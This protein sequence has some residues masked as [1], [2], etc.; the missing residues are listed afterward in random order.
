MVCN[1]IADAR[2][3]VDGRAWRTVAQHLEPSED[4]TLKDCAWV[5]VN[6]ASLDERVLGV[7]KRP[8]LCGKP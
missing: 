1:R 2:N 4:L 8:Q 5:V 7:N 6:V 3:Q